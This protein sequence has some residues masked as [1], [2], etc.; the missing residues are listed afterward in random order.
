[1]WSRLGSSSTSAGLSDHDETSLPAFPPSA[2]SA[3]TSSSSAAKNAAAAACFSSSSSVAVVVVEVVEALV[4]VGFRD[5]CFGCSAA[6]SSSF[7]KGKSLP[8][9]SSTSTWVLSRTTERTVLVVSA[10]MTS[11]ARSSEAAAVSSGTTG[12]AVA[13]SAARACV[14]VVV[15]VL[16]LK[17]LELLAPVSRFCS[18]RWRSSARSCSSSISWPMFF[19]T[20]PALL[21]VLSVALLAAPPGPLSEVEPGSTASLLRSIVS[22]AL[23]TMSLT[24]SLTF[25]GW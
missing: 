20:A 4:N 9:T 11:A 6:R 23:A 16:E 24:N 13:A 25:T 15:V 5:F 21:L 19:F 10:G 3:T 8:S 18:V 14:P 12:S 7:S 17:E 22:R 2:V 1:M